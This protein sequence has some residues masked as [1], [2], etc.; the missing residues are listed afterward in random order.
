MRLEKL[1]ESISV[2]IELDAVLQMWVKNFP[3]IVTP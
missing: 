2:S 1:F 3:K